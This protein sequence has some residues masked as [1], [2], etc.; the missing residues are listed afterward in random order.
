[1]SD[2]H[3]SHSH[4]YSARDYAL[5][6]NAYLLRSYEHLK[7]LRETRDDRYSGMAHACYQ[8]AVQLFLMAAIRFDGRPVAAPSG[9]LPTVDDLLP[10]LRGRLRYEAEVALRIATSALTRH[11]WRDFAEALR[12]R[13]ERAE[14]SLFQDPNLVLDLDVS[15]PA[16]DGADA[17]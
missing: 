4:A 17:G 3:G 2:L 5:L 10:Q 8:Q 1:M 9:T 11:Y 14:P 6:A 7:Q 12:Q 13:F 16:T 15:A